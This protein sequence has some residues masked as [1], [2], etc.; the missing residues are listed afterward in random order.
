M[1]WWLFLSIMSTG[2]RI[3][4]LM[5]GDRESAVL[6][7]KRSDTKKTWKDTS[8]IQV[9]KWHLGSE[10]NKGKV[11]RA[12]TSWQRGSQPIDLWVGKD[13]KG[14]AVQLLL[15]R[16]GNRG[17]GK[18]HGVPPGCTAMAGIVLSSGDSQPIAVSLQSPLP[19]FSRQMNSNER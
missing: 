13:P 9:R 19:Y 18:G 2:E 5:G 16:Q 4:F 8:E 3:S 11:V 1:L 7:L 15:H 17:P 10:D 12:W 6:V 14:H